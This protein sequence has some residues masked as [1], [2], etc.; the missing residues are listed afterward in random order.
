MNN[1][2]VT[3]HSWSTSSFGGSVDTSPMELS[4]LGE[5]LNVCRSTSGRLFALRC[6]AEKMNGFV[7]GRFVTTLA[8]A[9][10]VLIGV[11]LL[12]L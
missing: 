9:V 1:D 5:H 8:V 2:S 12:G 3:T 4:A 7:A 10:T 11:G 6:A